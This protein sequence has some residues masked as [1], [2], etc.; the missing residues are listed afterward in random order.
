MAFAFLHTLAP[1][2]SLLSASSHDLQ[3][4]QGTLDPWNPV[5]IEQDP[6]SRNNK[7]KATA[8]TLG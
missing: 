8:A 3:V 2:L 4:L 1:F 5:G 6:L 7:S